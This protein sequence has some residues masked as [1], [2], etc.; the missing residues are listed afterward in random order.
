[1][2]RSDLQEAVVPGAKL[3]KHDKQNKQTPL[4]GEGIKD[5]LF[6]RCSGLPLAEFLTAQL[7]YNGFYYQA[8]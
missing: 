1:M 6:A 7:S 8:R 2:A 3:R 4:R 5:C